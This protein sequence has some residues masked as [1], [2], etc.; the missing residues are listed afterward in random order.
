MTI[1]EK[2]YK[3]INESF[4]DKLDEAMR[5]KGVDVETT[6]NFLEGHLVTKTVDGTDMTQEQMEYL[7]G[8]SDGYCE[9]MQQI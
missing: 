4:R 9:A 2:L 7:K 3:Q 8:F 5:V 1:K 6:Y